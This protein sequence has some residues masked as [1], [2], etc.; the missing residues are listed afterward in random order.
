MH[1]HGVWAWALRAWSKI[2]Q[3]R[4]QRVSFLIVYLLH[5]VAGG[6][7]AA[8]TPRAVNYTMGELVAYVWAGFLILGGTVAAIA[9]LPGWNFVERFGLLSLMFG[10]G[11]TSIFIIANPWEPIGLDIIVW[12]FVTGWV[13]MFL[14]RL[15]ETRLYD[16]APK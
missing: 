16:I 9:V 12:A 1:D 11:L 3:P 2:A 5:I 8:T 7:I 14:Y 15:W 4:V 6:A 13:V 10:I